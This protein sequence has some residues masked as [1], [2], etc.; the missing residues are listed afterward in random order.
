MENKVID[1]VDN[2][3]RISC[4]PDIIFKI[5]SYISFQDISRLEES[6][7][8]F[9][10]I[11]DRSRIWKRKLKQE[12]DFDVS[13]DSKEHPREIYWQLKYLGHYCDKKCYNR[14]NICNKE[15]HCF[16]LTKCENCDSSAY[17]LP[18]L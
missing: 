16:N 5:L 6:S 7:K 1:G 15:T 12:F 8:T 9:E 14:C 13:C 4:E 11:F 18:G 17:L 10:S 2:W 3:K